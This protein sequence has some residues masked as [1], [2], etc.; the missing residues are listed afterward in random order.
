M[1][2]DEEKARDVTV[3]DVRGLTLIAD[4]FVLCTGNSPTHIRAIAEGVQ[5]KLRERFNLRTKPEGVA[6]SEW[7]VMDYGDVIAH[8][9]SAEVRQFYD[10]E[11]LWADARRTSW[12][13]AAV[14][15]K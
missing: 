5:E 8:I 14:L 9:F 10:L 6:E 11:G 7:V 2:L 4:Y 12:T 15:V 1:A 3:L 13:P